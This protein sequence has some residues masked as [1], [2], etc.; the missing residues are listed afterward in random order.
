MHHMPWIF[1]KRKQR[2]SMTQTQ[3]SGPKL[4]RSYA[5]KNFEYIPSP[6]PSSSSSPRSST[7][8]QARCREAASFR[9]E[10]NDG[11][12]DFIYQSLGISGPDDFEIPRELWDAIKSTSLDV[13]QQSKLRQFDLVRSEEP[14][15]LEVEGVDDDLYSNYEDIFLKSEVVGAGNMCVSE[16]PEKHEVQGFV[17]DLCAR[18]EDSVN[19]SEVVSA[20]KRN[21]VSGGNKGIKG[22]RPPFLLTPPPAMSLPPLD[23][24]CSTWDLVKALAPDGDHG[25][26]LRNWETFHSPVE[27]KEDGENADQ[28]T[29]NESRFWETVV[30]SGSCSFTTS[31]DDDSSSATTEPVSIIS[32]VGRLRAYITGWVKGELLGQGSFGKVYKAFASDGSFFAVKEVSLLDKGSQGKQSIFQLEQEI[33]LLSQFR[34][35]NIVQYLGTDKDESKLY[36][37]LELVTEGSL[38]SLYQTYRLRDSQVSSYTRQILLGLKYLHDRNIV[39]RDIKCANILV[40][41]NGMVKLADFGL[42]KATKLNDLKSCK[43][44]AFWMAPEVVNQRNEGYGLSADI[45]SL[46]CTVLEMLTSHVPYHPLEFVQ[47]LFRI[48]KGLPPPIPDS[49]SKDAC[50]FVLQCLRNERCLGHLEDGITCEVNDIR[51]RCQTAL[52]EE[53][54]RVFAPISC[55][56]PELVS[57]CNVGKS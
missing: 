21:C 42:A 45:W 1:A 8:Q 14:K 53:V 56:L 24:M 11:E 44:S 57:S 5:S 30:L 52:S 49:L 19:A 3:S 22:D 16:D 25:L 20:N 35:D 40:A 41:S 2:N 6:S 39:H 47:A 48:G 9:I 54:D 26:P 33:E 15:N 29:L 43:G 18:F 34:H 36:I 32:P 28:V 55:F 13:T 38:A 23:N 7:V 50:D 46:G 51:I 27:D 10:G 4:V 17:D 37:F 31:Q 12:L